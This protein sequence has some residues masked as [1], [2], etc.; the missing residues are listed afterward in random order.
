MRK[1]VDRMDGFEIHG[2]KITAKVKMIS[3]VLP[4]YPRRL[5]TT[6]KPTEADQRV[7]QSPGLALVLAQKDDD[8]EAADETIS[9]VARHRDPDPQR[10]SVMKAKID[11]DLD[12]SPSD[13][14]MYVLNLSNL[15]L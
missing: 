10:K 13:E 2:R 14:K 9:L 11:P 15:Y 5:N 12:Q 3:Y 4:S 1:A 7:D 6:L 8:H